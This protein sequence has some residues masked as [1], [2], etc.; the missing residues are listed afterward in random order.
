MKYESFRA[1][2]SQMPEE[3]PAL[4]FDGGSMTCGALRERVLALAEQFRGEPWSALGVLSPASPEWIVTVFAAVVAGKRVVLL[5]PLLPEDAAQRLLTAT[6]ADRLF[7]ADGELAAALTLVPPAP[8]GTAGE[9]ELLF[10]T[11]GTTQSSRAAVLTSRSLCASAWNGQQMLACGEGDTVLAVLPLNH[12]FGFVCT[13][14]WPLCYGA[15]V[16][17]GRGLR[18]L[19]E[20][21]DFFRPTILTAV[22]TLLE[23]LLAHGA[24]NP[25]LRCV[26]VGASPCSRAALEAA[27]ARGLEVRF[28]YGLT[29]TSSGVAISIR[30]GDPY[31]MALCPDSVIALADDGEVLVRTPCM[32]EGY[33]NDPA[34]TAAV[35]RD[36]TLYT[37]DL[38]RFDMDGR[39]RITGRKKDIL[40]LPSG[41]KVFCPEWEEELAGLLGPRDLAV[42]SREGKLVLVLRGEAAER[43]GLWEKLSGFNLTRP[44]DQRLTALELRDGPLPRTAT[45]KIRRWAL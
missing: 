44:F 5:D 19:A 14:L 32:M 9:G 1:M 41:G 30:G 6:A 18:R 22:P 39:L 24:L 25:E 40:V 28:G 20:D 31:A 10:F 43:A 37:G 4:V 35:L 36:G 45:G 23:F 12:V 11:S 13:L 8:C 16:A 2:L 38:G 21:P 26:L 27:A 17:L 7:C 33:W 42:A 15:A 3:R 34:A 29:E